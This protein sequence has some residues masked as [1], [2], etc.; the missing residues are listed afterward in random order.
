MTRTGACGA[1]AGL[2]GLS[3]HRRARRAKTPVKTSNP[4]ALGQTIGFRRGSGIER[5]QTLLRLQRI[6]GARRGPI[7]H[8][9]CQAGL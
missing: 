9:G 8:L 5:G 4:R 2:R 1:Q 6:P 3:A 7:A